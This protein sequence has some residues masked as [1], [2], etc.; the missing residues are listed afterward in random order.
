[1]DGYTEY[2]YRAMKP[3]WTHP[4]FLYFIGTKIP[5]S[6]LTPPSMSAAVRPRGLE[7]L[8]GVL[9]QASSAPLAPLTWP[10]DLHRPTLTQVVFALFILH[11][12]F[13]VDVPRPADSAAF[14]KTLC[15]NISRGVMYIYNTE[16][17]MEA[18]LEPRR[19]ATARRRTS[20]T[21][22]PRLCGC[23]DAQALENLVA[24]FA[25]SAAFYEHPCSI[26]S[27][28]VTTEYIEVPG[29]SSVPGAGVAGVVLSFPTPTLLFPLFIFLPTKL[30]FHHTQLI[31]LPKK[32]IFNPPQKIF[33][34]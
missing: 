12:F 34:I 26:I 11:V 28:D 10:Q 23:T 4:A 22:P 18:C 7:Y 32:L 30:I 8:R 21:S 24:R 20:T 25:D 1:M 3:Q 2:R 29:E 5:H 6:N 15:S 19:P 16:Y 9:Q 33:F 13:T 17:Y 14:T 27:R 31:F